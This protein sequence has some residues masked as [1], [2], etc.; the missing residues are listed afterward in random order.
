MVNWEDDSTDR[1]H[2]RPVDDFVKRVPAVILYLSRTN[3]VSVTCTYLDPGF[4]SSVQLLIQSRIEVSDY[5]ANTHGGR[6]FH[7]VSL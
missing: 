7:K 5:M 1:L 6:Q 3:V 2:T 4:R